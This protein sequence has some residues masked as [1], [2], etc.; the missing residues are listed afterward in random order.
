[1]ERFVNTNL[2]D[3]VIGLLV[4]RAKTKNISHKDCQ[5]VM[6]RYSLLDD[7]QALYC[8]VAYIHAIEAGYLD[9]YF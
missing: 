7:R 9:H 4:M 6:F 5:C 8:A 1:M 3:C 2:K